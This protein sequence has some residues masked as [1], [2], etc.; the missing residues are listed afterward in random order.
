MV[1]ISRA[2]LRSLRPSLPG[3]PGRLG[4]R[5]QRP[6]PV[7]PAELLLQ[8]IKPVVADVPVGDHEPA[9]VLAEELLRRRLAAGGIDPVARHQRSG[10]NP[11]ALVRPLEPPDGLIGVN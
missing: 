8:D 4:Q 10:R 5:D 11:Q 1:M 9:E 2:V 6:Y 7:S 3:A